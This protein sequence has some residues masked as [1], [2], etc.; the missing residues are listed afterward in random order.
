MQATQGMRACNKN[1]TKQSIYAARQGRRACNN[2]NMHNQKLKYV[3]RVIY[4]I[5]AAPYIGAYKLYLFICGTVDM[6]SLH[7]S[8]LCFYSCFSD[9]FVVYLPGNK[10]H[11]VCVCV[12]AY[13]FCCLWSYIMHL[14]NNQVFNYTE[15]LGYCSCTCSREK[16]EEEGEGREEGK[17]EEEKDEDEKKK[18]KEE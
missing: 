9:F 15:V 16:D 3:G 10:M 11:F 2:N 13:P 14:N 1:N 7:P 8:T 12:Q 6:S 17:E 18:E 4:V 5:F